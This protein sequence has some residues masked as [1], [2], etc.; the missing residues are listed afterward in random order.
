MT[1]RI[2]LVLLLAWL[3]APG[4]AQGAIVERVVAIV[5]ERAILLSELRQRATPYLI[6]IHQ[7]PLDDAQRAAAISQ[8]YKAVLDRMVEE[9]LQNR[10]ATRARISISS[11]E[12]D[13]ALERVAQQN[14][15]QVSEILAEAERS[16]LSE[17]EYRNELRRQ[18]LEAKLLNLRVQGRIRITESDLGSLYRK[19]QLEERQKLDF[20]AAKIVI[21]GRSTTRASSLQRR[22]FAERIAQLA[23][24][25]A[26]FEELARRYSEDAET[27][28]L[29]GL[30][31]RMKPGTLPPSID[32]ALLNLEVGDTSSVLKDGTDFVILQLVERADSTLPAFEEARAELQN[33][34]YMQK[35]D[36]ARRHW[37][38][39]LKRRAHIEIRL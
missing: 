33:R 29:G 31:P 15:L 4:A 9:E 8:L 27:R 12:V 18:V 30:M 20:R 10:A 17:V 35:M 38:D 21:S 16:G 14:N 11:K 25:G 5:E 3:L 1:R 6:R 7:E 24:A 23:A 22:R 39:G 34:I 2:W 13:Q 36:R 37:L 32:Q 28:T 26:N 19:L